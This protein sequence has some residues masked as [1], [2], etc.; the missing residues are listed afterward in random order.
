MQETWVRSL[1]WEDPL[2]EGM[3][4]TPAFSPGKSY[5]QRSLRGYSPGS[6]RAGHDRAHMQSDYTGIACPKYYGL[7]DSYAQG[8]LEQI[9]LFKHA[10][11][12]FV[13]E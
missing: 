12:V 9:Y 10:L 5:G 2:E 8:R 7:L 13:S 6:Q 4:P 11:Q 3:Q 1:G